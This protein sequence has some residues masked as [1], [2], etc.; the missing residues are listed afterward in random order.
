MGGWWGLRNAAPP[1]SKRHP[2]PET[3]RLH[4]ES[5]DP[6]SLDPTLETRSPLPDTLIPKLQTRILNP[7]PEARS[8]KA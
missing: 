2:T 8:R 5:L 4:P 7:C 6:Q 1:P 3:R